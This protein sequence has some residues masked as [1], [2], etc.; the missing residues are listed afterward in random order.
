MKFYEKRLRNSKSVARLRSVVCVYRK[1]HTVKSSSIRPFQTLHMPE[2][3]LYLQRSHY[4]YK[5]STALS[6]KLYTLL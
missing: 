5:Y 1:S 6:N 2:V 3:E 4:T